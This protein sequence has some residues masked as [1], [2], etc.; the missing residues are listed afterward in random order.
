M[1]CNESDYNDSILRAIDEQMK[2]HQQQLEHLAQ[3]RSL[4]LSNT[5]SL[6]ATLN[7]K[8]VVDEPTVISSKAVDAILDKWPGDREFSSEELFRELSK[9]SDMTATKKRT[10][11]AMLCSILA[12]RVKQNKIIKCDRG[13]YRKVTPIR[14]KD[15]EMNELQS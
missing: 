13:L 8:C 6:A 15:M 7:L 3:V 10:A 1:S 14:E 2:F 9:N 11:S 4:Y 5:D 12:R